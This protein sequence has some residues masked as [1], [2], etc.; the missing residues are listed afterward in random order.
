MGTFKYM[1]RLKEFKLA[2]EVKKEDIEKVKRKTL[3]KVEGAYY[4]KR[5]DGLVIKMDELAQEVQKNYQERV[6]RQ[7]HLLVEKKCDTQ[8][9]FASTGIYGTDSK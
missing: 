5:I 8:K 9:V 6:K 2:E 3:F 1:I 7:Y 4:Y